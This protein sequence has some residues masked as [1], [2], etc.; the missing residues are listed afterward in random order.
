MSHIPGAIPENLSPEPLSQEPLLPEQLS[1][2]YNFCWSNCHIFGASVAGA[3]VGGAIVGGAIVGGA[4]VGGAI[5]GGAIVAGANVGG[6][7]CRR[8]KCRQSKCL[9]AFVAEHL[10]YF[11]EQLSAEHMSWNRNYCLCACIAWTDTLA[12]EGLWLAN[13]SAASG[14]CILRLVVPYKHFRDWATQISRV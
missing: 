13:P 5:I 4:I 1:A 3:I 8:S 7:K 11:S 12:K 10:S 2:E 6:A 9:G 14:F